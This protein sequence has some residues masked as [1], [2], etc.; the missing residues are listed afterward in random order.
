[1]IRQIAE[2]LRFCPSIALESSFSSFLPES[3]H[4]L[5]MLPGLKRALN[6]LSFDDR[7]FPP[8]Y[9]I[10]EGHRDVKPED[11]TDPRICGQCHT[12]QYEG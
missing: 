2:N 4:I 9:I 8:S 5:L 3:V 11:W 12:C 10:T 1:M 6:F 7:R